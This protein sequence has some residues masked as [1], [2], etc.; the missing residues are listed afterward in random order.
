MINVVGTMIILSRTMKELL[1]A[2]NLCK[3]LNYSAVISFVVPLSLFAKVTSEWI[4]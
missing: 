4:I 3:V 1:R 2:A